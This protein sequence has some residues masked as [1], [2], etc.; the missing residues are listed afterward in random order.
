MY[1]YESME[2]VKTHTMK[3]MVLLEMVY[4]STFGD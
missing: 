1:C 2:A 3:I 4:R